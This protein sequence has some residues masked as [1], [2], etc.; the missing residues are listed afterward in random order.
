MAVNK[1][2]INELRE[3]VDHL[4]ERQNG[5]SKEIHKL[6]EEINLLIT[7]G[8]QNDKG[9]EEKKVLER[10]LTGPSK[11]VRQSFK[12]RE[13]LEKFIGENLINKIGIAITVIGV[14]IGAKYAID[15]ELI[16]PLTRIILAYVFGLGLLGFAIRLKKNYEN[17]SAVL[18]SG[19]MAI[20]YFVTYAGYGFYQLFPQY[21]AFF[22][23]VI[24]TA[25][26]VTAALKYNM[27][28]I[29]H[30][31][32]VGAYAVPF[33]LSDGSGNVF[34]LFSYMS[35]INLGILIIALKKYW[36]PLYY[37]SFLIT[38]LIFLFWYKS[39]YHE[40][41]HF[42]I[43]LTFISVFYVIFYIMFLANKLI[44]KEKFE[45]I[46]IVSML[47]NSFLFYG[48]GYTIL[49]H[50][51]AGKNLL[52]VYTLV[53]ALIHLL[54]SAVVYR[55]NL[56]DRNL[57]YLVSGLV[58]TFITI[59]VP[60]QMDGNWV[61][62]LWV[63]E[64]A[65]LFWIG[66]SKSVSFYEVLSYA[67]MFQAFFSLIHD[68][69]TVYNIN[70]PDYVRF[71]PV[72]NVNFLSSLLFAAAF[73]FINYQNKIKEKAS[74]L[75]QQKD[76]NLLMT[77]A[78][79]AILLIVLYY[80]FEL[81]ISTFWDQLNSDS[82]R[83]I[84]KPGEEYPI[85]YWDTDLLRYSNIW[86]L[87]YSILFLSVLSFLNIRKLRH[88]GLGL[89]NI[90]MNIITLLAL[91]TSGLLTLSLLRES[92]L[93]QQL[94]EYYYRGTFNLVIR[95]ITLASAGLLLTSIFIYLKQDF[96]RPWAFNFNVGFDFLF[97]SS[98][99]WIASSELIS[100]MDIM[101]S[102]QSYKL[103]LSI[104]WG[105]YALVLI[106]LGIWKKKKHLRIGA[107]VFFGITLLKLFFYD[108]SHLDTIAKT[109]VF[110]T[111]GIILLIISFLY[112]KYKHLISIENP[113]K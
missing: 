94:S 8:T 49:D 4:S 19:A 43:A 14:S 87:N 99:I 108:I 7:A 9:K 67:L 15:H 26:T 20:M 18:L 102:E 24:L 89:F 32:L 106:V 112:N 48:I 39:N 23:M 54:V 52:G 90:A 82:L 92:Y 70:S 81:E 84:T 73:G 103:G 58:L 27:Q 86:V 100:W 45:I 13:D 76:L 53:N 11:K 1:D 77:F 37:S 97:Y 110:V 91:L 107:I 69:Q 85:N 88:R 109:I 50:H 96:L 12:I 66:R 71:T 33:L 17:F 65:L 93:L 105:V 28:V 72:L 6:Q 38:W 35:I 44:Q 30:V 31:G 101:K 61:T 78:I 83:Q 75:L 47:L 98:L 95:Y 2:R 46:D 80:S 74:S 63:F 10:D 113:N 41:E 51:D 22:L 42:G 56:A 104:L 36:K 111:L 29:A 79:P 16:S 25:F 62:L 34:I 59:A 57:F 68:W 21:L 3:L 60:V 40:L 64:A 55:K 5:L